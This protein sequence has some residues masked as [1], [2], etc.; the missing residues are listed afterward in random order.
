MYMLRQFQ[1]FLIKKKKKKKTTKE[2]TKAERRLSDREVISYPVFYELT[3]FI[4]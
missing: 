1:L 2:L 3:S 4:L